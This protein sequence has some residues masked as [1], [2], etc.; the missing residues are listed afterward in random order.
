M[1]KKW[2]RSERKLLTNFKLNKV[3]KIP[4]ITWT[5]YFG[6]KFCSQRFEIVM[7]VFFSDFFLK[8]FGLRIKNNLVI[9][10]RGNHVICYYEKEWLPFTKKV[11][12]VTCKSLKT[13]RKYMNLVKR[14]QVK[15]AQDA[16]KIAGGNLK[17]KSWSELKKLYLQFDQLHKDFFIGPIWIPFIIEPF[18][19]RAAEAELKKLLKKFKKEDNLHD[20]FEI[21]FS[22]EQKNAVI[23][24]H[25]SL[26]EIA[27]AGKS[28][29]EKLLNFHVKK[30]EWLPCYDINDKPWTKDYFKKG[31]SKLLKKE[32][33]DLRTEIREI[34]KRFSTRKKD[35]KRILKELKPSQK[36]KELL[37]MAHE[38]AFIKD[39]RDDYRRHGSF[40]IQPLYHEIGRRVGLD[41][42]E[43]TQLI[44]KEMVAFLSSGK[45]LISKSVI[46]SRVK[47]YVLLRKYGLPIVISQGRKM[48]KMI[49]EELG[50]QKMSG[51]KVIRG[52]VASRGKT[53]GPVQVIYTKHDLRK[54]KQGDIMVSVT[55]HP[56]FV[57]A[58]R[59]CKAIVTDEGGITSHAAIVS[60]ELKIPCLVG[61]K[62]A[63]K[64]FKDGNLVEVDAQKGIIKKL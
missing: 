12:A 27:L 25:L 3:K 49:R 19:A 48:K 38:M 33:T 50:E 14:W 43:V 42:K 47:G 4:K 13:F 58:M 36:Q 37:I 64:I 29:S 61:T 63:T 15:Y 26:F 35:F 24:E 40:S 28:K 8:H 30:Y 1:N 51:V 18:I 10:E 23:N 54:V 11:F 16:Q 44:K 34:N 55:T 60:R 57:P 32:E 20:Y 31:L 21:I 45:L 2:Q 17:T 7:R 59:K 53:S 5:H 56:D 39:E 46:K 41:I 52:I 62:I 6:R 9:P 22:P